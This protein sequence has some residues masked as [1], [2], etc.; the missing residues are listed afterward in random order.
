MLLA[1]S[2]LGG[3]SPLHAR[4]LT[5]LLGAL[6][7]LPL[8]TKGIA[9]WAGGF[10]LLF[11]ALAVAGRDPGR[12]LPW[13]PLL[14]TPLSLCILLYLGYLWL[15]IL[16]SN[17]LTAKSLLEGVGKALNIGLFVALVALCRL[18]DPRIV[19]RALVGYAVAA[20]LI[21]AVAVPLFLWGG[22]DA[23]GRL[24]A[25]A[26]GEN[27]IIA[28][29]QFGVAILFLVGLACSGTVS[30]GTLGDRRRLALS[31]VL[32]GLLLA[33]L[34]L[35]KSRGPILGTGVALCV[36]LAGGHRLFWPALS[37][38]AAAAVVFAAGL[39]NL[40]MLMARGNSYRFDLW[41]QA[42]E[43]AW[44]HP[45]FGHG[46]GSE[47]VLVMPDGLTFNFPHN[48]F[49]GALLFNGLAGVLLL[50]ALFTAFGVAAWRTR[51]S[52]FPGPAL[53][54]FAL[55]VGAFDRMIDLRNFSPEYLY[56]WLPAGVLIADW[57]R[58][59]A[60]PAAPAT[61]HPETVP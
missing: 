17:D 33:A 52:G 48:I 38:L 59:A 40:D 43:M 50:A 4:P 27:Q 9:L 31:V 12:P 14:A 57:V 11:A 2:A 25:L 32:A 13:R 28:A 34:L 47:L 20:A 42:L 24:R 23:A 21:A 53:L 30:S 46:S 55:L 49:V 37:L 39:L 36:V 61:L 15:G 41:A 35:T 19:D 5:W 29:I 45:V 26:K 10:L 51:S 7:V 22:G 44:Q 18:R 1:S 58:L 8:L 16:W 56:V 54:L 6:L 60:V 3:P